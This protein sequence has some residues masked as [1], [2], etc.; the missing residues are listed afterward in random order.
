MGY[1]WLLGGSKAIIQIFTWGR[2]AT[3]M[4]L[5]HVQMVCEVLYVTGS[6]FGVFCLLWWATTPLS[7]ASAKVLH[8]MPPHVLIDMHVSLHFSFFSISGVL[9]KAFCL[10]MLCLVLAFTYIVF[11]VLAWF[12]HVA[13]VCV[14]I[15]VALELK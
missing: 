10:I 9:I 7:L 4:E 2:H 3:G 1:G 12:P 13:T 15:C 8:Y 14:C 11:W 5:D 6:I